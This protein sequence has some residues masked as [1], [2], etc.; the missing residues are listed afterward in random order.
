[1][2]GKRVA[3]TSIFCET[4]SHGGAT[5]LPVEDEP[6]K[7]VGRPGDLLFFQ[8]D[9][10][11]DRALHAA[12]PVMDGQKSTFTQWHRLGVS[13]EKPWD[14]FEAVGRQHSPYGSSR[15]QGLRFGDKVPW[16][17]VEL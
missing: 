7:F 2:L 13:V 14:T 3:T 12:C 5:V 8:Y 4:A 16:D 9:P 10:Q 1:M 15:W 17:S 6:L 11:P